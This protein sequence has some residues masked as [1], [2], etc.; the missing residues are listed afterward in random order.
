MNFSEGRNLD[1]VVGK[2]SNVDKVVVSDVAGDDDKVD[3]AGVE[4]S[5]VEFVVGSDDDD[6]GLELTSVKLEIDGHS[7]N[8]GFGTY[9]SSG[10]AVC[11]GTGIV[12]FN[13]A[14]KHCGAWNCNTPVVDGNVT[15]TT[16]KKK[17]A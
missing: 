7:G 14:C 5:N 17:W 3:V 8:T 13:G 2:S 11:A 10:V 12:V 6:D 4:E 16:C 9:L 15:C 1:D